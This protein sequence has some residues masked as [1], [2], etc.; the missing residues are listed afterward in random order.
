M[1][2]TAAALARGACSVEHA[3][4]IARTMAALPVSLSTEQLQVGE[5]QLAGWATEFD[6]GE[7]A[8]LGRSLIHL[9]DAD[10]L[11]D[12]EQRAYERR[13]FA[14]VDRGD[15]SAQMSGQLDNESAAIVRAALDPLAAPAPAADGEPDR[16][17]GGQRM[18]D[19]LVELARRALG[20]GE[21]MP[22][23]HAVRP[24]VSVLVRLDGLMAKVGESGLTPGELASGGP[25]WLP[26]RAGSA[27]MPESAGSLPTRLGYRSM[28]AVNTGS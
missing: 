16:R 14:L 24:H 19:A 17:T 26:P 27:A 22:A 12:R 21:T 20:A 28:L 25:I 15:G 11:E 23:G 18:A 7:V 6:P 13:S 10:T 5:G 8:N 2:A 4:V 3:S 9:L 1:P